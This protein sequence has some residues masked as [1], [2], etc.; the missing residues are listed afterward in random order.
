[1][2]LLKEGIYQA[3]RK[4]PT[5]INKNIINNL[6]KSASKVDRFRSRIL[7]H[8]LLVLIHNICLYVLITGLWCQLLFTHFQKVF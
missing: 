7:Y 3:T 4:K 1:M 8:S 6:K 5:V 2:K